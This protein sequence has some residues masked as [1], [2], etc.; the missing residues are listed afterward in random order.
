MSL[1]V[2]WIFGTLALPSIKSLAAPAHSFIAVGR[3]QGVKILFRGSLFS[4]EAL[5]TVLSGLVLRMKVRI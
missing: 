5:R 1:L 4:G 3:S 2:C